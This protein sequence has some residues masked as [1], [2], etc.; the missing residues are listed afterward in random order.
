[1]HKC[2]QIMIR[3]ESFSMPA[4][5]LQ[6]PLQYQR[7]VVQLLIHQDFLRRFDL[8]HFR[9]VAAVVVGEPPE[10]FKVKVRAAVLAEKQDAGQKPFVVGDWIGM[11][12][13][14]PQTDPN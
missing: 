8:P 3:T 14:L 9:R 7:S 5:V 10:S 1:M 11:E 4:S 6:H 2:V 12:I 13:G